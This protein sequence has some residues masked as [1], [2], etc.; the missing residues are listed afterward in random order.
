M[1][2]AIYNFL[3]TIIIFSFIQCSNN[4]TEVQTHNLFL[5]FKAGI[6]KSEFI[7]QAK[8]DARLELL[9]EGFP[10]YKYSIHLSNH[11]Y[12]TNVKPIFH[13]ESKE[14]YWILIQ[15]E[16]KSSEE[17]RELRDVFQNKY[18]PGTFLSEYT[19]LSD[20]R[21][22]PCLSWQKSSREVRFCIDSFP[23]RSQEMLEAIFNKKTPV[24][25][26]PQFIY[27]FEIDYKDKNIENQNLKEQTVNEL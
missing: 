26:V 27:Q 14:L 5:D 9:N 21:K 2:A 19:N 7:T 18:G 22:T 20:F 23:D 12:T 4:R 15:G 3:H 1:K 11:T 16:V 13:L 8:Q 24:Q 17:L 6:K 25:L 10:E